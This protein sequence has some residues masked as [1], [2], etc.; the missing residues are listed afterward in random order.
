[1]C[2]WLE[3]VC[4]ELFIVI[5]GIDKK[6]AEGG[7]REERVASTHAAIRKRERRKK[8]RKM[9]LLLLLFVGK[10]WEGGGMPG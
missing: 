8:G 5:N 2:V 7:R 10:G 3:E 6:E 9:E 1:M 4:V